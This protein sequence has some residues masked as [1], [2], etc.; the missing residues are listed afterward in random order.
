MRIFAEQP[1]A[2][3]SEVEFSKN[4]EKMAEL[5]N[6]WYFSVKTGKNVRFL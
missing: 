1:L 4:I 2:Y 5:Q 6:L 3:L